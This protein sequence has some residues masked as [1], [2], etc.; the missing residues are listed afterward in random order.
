MTAPAF[1]SVA[2]DYFRE[3][4]IDPDL[5]AVA[6]VREQDGKIL[7][8]YP[9]S[10]GTTYHRERSLNG[11]GPAKVKQPAGQPLTLYW[12]LPPPERLEAVIVAEG[13]SDALAAI[14]PTASS[15]WGAVRVAAIPGCGFPVDRLVEQL[16]GFDVREAFLVLDADDA[17]RAYT[18]RAVSALRTAGIDP[19][20]LELEDGTDLADNLVRAD[21]RVGWLENALADAEIARDA[22]ADHAEPAP[23]VASVAS[24][25]VDDWPEAPDPPAFHGLAGQI[26]GAI[27]PHSEADSAAL[28]ISVLIAFG[29][30]CGRGPGF[31]VEGDFHATNLFGLIVGQ[32]AKGRKGTSWGQARRIFEAADPEWTDE[33][34]A[35]GLTSGEGLIYHV[36][37]AQTKQ[38]PVKE[39]GKP[40]GEYVEEIIDE[41][42]QDK[43]MLIFESEFAQV[44]KVMAREG[45]TLSPAIRDLWDRGDVRTLS[46]NSPLRATG[47]L[48]SILA[49]GTVEELRRG[50]TATEVANG[51][52]NRFLFVAA[53][54]SKILPEGGALD[55]GELRSLA[56]ELRHAIRFAGVQRTLDR[57]PAARARWA[58]VY[59]ELSEGR[60][61]LLGAA[62]S[63]A[64]AQVM[65]LA[66]IY[67]LLDQS[68]VI[69][70]EHLEAALALWDYCDRS[71]AYVFGTALGDPLADDLLERIRDAG[72]KGLSRT[73]IRD[74]LGRHRRGDEIDRALAQLSR[75]DLARREQV[76]T[77][78][79]PA[80][81]WFA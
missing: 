42:V 15:R 50:L 40:T 60:P 70:L 52:A 54:R 80:E 14:E 27:A 49:H 20:V 78:G 79:R 33:R 8:P 77:G 24:V 69:G 22:A 16:A 76:S 18:E 62:T 73:D 12:P 74:A 29:N 64:E 2:I 65:R 28:L 66:V 7:F 57:D 75:L 35:G 23:S 32:T 51:F 21:D 1:S 63:R 4:A 72:P 36:R 59:P 9:G 48:V 71:A 26:V 46:K 34:I 68:S 45:N 17:G 25:A 37:D 41:G 44:S 47:A 31:K 61:G 5:A 10:D 19:L 58:Q 43:R 13:E 81:R 38:V 53:R 56:D 39:R 3:R 55:D 11:G 67:A 30:A 6:G